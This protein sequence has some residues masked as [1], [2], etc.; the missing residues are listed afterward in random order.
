MQVHDII[1]RFRSNAEVFDA[2]T[3]GVS[4]PQ[5]R[6]KPSPDEWSV[7]EVVNHLADEEVEDFRHRIDLTL[8]RPGEQWLPINP[9]AW[10]EDRQYNKRDLGESMER[11]LARRARSL[12]WLE[13]LDQPDWSL[14]YSHAPAGEL[15]AG[16]VL[17]S[18]L[19]HDFLHVRQLN[20]LHRQYLAAELS[21]Y[22]PDYAGPW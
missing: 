4:E 10:A 1:E 5:A 22:S 3:R 12:R 20:R 2:L 16:D 15:R 9:K 17:T 19:A 6:W 7:L 14:R 13:G 18:W 8:H 11:L 21:D